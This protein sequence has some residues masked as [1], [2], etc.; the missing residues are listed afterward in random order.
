ME[1]Q[2][3]NA[4]AKVNDRGITALAYNVKLRP[5]VTVG[6]GVSLDTQNLN[7]AAH[8]VCGHKKS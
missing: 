3:R 4:Q 1:A 6:L 7:E 2:K 5:G 8:K